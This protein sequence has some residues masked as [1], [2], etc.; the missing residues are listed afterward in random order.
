MSRLVL[1]SR[2]P[3]RRAILEQLGVQFSV[4]VPEVEELEEGPPH[5]VALENAYRKAAAVAGEG[6]G[7]AVLGVDTVVSL[8]ARMY[9]KPFDEAQARDTLGA[10]SG[11]RHTVIS[12]VCLIGEDGRSRTAAESTVVQFQTLDDRVIDWYLS[13]SEWRERAGGYAIQGR[14][15]AL[16]ARIEG[17]FL[18]VVGLPVA[19]LLELAPGLLRG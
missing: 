12:G 10:L 5:E 11:R 16:V 1:A 19:A 2:S 8:G 15:A 14:G 18:N 6:S 9:G 17:D 3:Q 13:S 7:G 4:E